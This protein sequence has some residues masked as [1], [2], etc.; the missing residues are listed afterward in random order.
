MA[1]PT[2]SSGSSPFL[3]VRYTDPSDLQG[4]RDPYL[5]T[6]SHVSMAILYRDKKGSSPLPPTPFSFQIRFS[7]RGKNLPNL[8]NL[9]QMETEDRIQNRRAFRDFVLDKDFYLCH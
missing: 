9:V 7:S 8:C 6:R 2:P 5:L 4:R 3:P 1:T